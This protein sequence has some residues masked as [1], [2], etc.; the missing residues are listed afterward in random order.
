MSKA[1]LLVPLGL[2]GLVGL[3]K[4]SP[5][6]SAIPKGSGPEPESKW[7]GKQFVKVETTAASGRKYET[8]MWEPVEGVGVYT[9]ARAKVASGQAPWVSYFYQAD[10]NTRTPAKTNVNDLGLTPDAAAQLLNVLRADQLL[11]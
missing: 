10:T 4:A 1:L 6:A 11:T 8:W 2:L 3:A 5:P 9:I 7:R